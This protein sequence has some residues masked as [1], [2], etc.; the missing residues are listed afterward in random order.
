MNISSPRNQIG[1]HTWQTKLQILQRHEVWSNYSS[2]AN[3]IEGPKATSPTEDEDLASPDIEESS[4]PTNLSMFPVSDDDPENQSFSIMD[5]LFQESEAQCCVR[6][7]PELFSECPSGSPAISRSLKPQ[8]PISFATCLEL[9]RPATRQLARGR[10]DCAGLA[11]AAGAALGADPSD[12]ELIALLAG[13]AGGGGGTA[14]QGAEVAPYPLAR[15]PDGSTFEHGLAAEDL[16]SSTA[17]PAAY[18]HMEDG[19]PCAALCFLDEEHEGGE[20]HPDGLSCS[21]QRAA[22]AESMVCQTL[23]SPDEGAHSE[24]SLPIR[25]T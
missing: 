20:V 6:R 5:K 18:R 14:G 9:S 13:C 24:C 17:T 21:R 12:L 4:S 8:L 7:H 16:L 25:A 11:A 10:V 3:T 23:I 19:F 22:G 2:G 1:I 15:T